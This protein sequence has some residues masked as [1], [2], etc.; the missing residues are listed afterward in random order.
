MHKKRIIKI[1]WKGPYGCQEVIDRMK[2]GGSKRNHWS[3]N[4]YGL[5]QIYGKHILGSKRTLLYIGQAADQTFSARFKQHKKEWIYGER[6]L[7]IYLGRIQ[8]GSSKWRKDVD[9]AEQILIYKY[10]PN[11][12]SSLKQDYPKLPESTCVRLQHFGKRARL[13]QIDRAPED[14][15][16]R[17]KK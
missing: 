9:I 12:N 4:D 15:E 2:D 13:K 11:Y 14:Y 3:G 7:K 10:T 5:Y 8:D 1:D 16:Y 6:G 17:K